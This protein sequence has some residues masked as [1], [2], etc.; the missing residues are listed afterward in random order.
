MTSENQE[1]DQQGRRG[2]YS[3][4]SQELRNLIVRNYEAGLPIKRISINLDVSR[5]TVQSIIKNYL[6]TG[7]NTPKA[8]GGCKKSKFQKL[9]KIFWKKN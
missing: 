8:K 4:I 2:P 5:S 6:E 7:N 1:N 9:L 3:K